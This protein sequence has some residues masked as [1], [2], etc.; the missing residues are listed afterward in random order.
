MV[1]R[2]L[3]I[4]FLLNGIQGMVWAQDSGR[5]SVIQAAQEY[6]AAMYGA[7]SGIMDNC[8]H[9]NFVKYGYY[10]KGSTE[11]FSDMTRITRDQMVQI[12]R[13]WNKNQW[14]PADPPKDVNLLDIQE[15]IAVVKLTAYWGVEYLHITKADSAWKIIQILSQNWSKKFPQEEKDQ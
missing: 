11:S 9:E 13:D 6:V 7:D 8:L 5:R 1:T 2:I 15:N 12:A 4:I 3:S 10:W 14:V